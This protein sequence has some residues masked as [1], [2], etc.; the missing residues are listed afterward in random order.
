MMDRRHFAL[1][2]ASVLA[3]AQAAPALAAKPP[4]TWDNLV[5]VKSK[6]LDYVYLLPGADFREYRKVMIDPTEIAFK[7]NWLKDYNNT[8]T[9]LSTRLSERDVQEAITKGSQAATEIL[10]EAFSEGGYPVVTEPGPDVLRLRTGV[11]NI[12]V[13]APEINMAGRSRSF[14]QEAGYATLIVE[15]RDSVSGALLGRAVDGKVA[16]DNS[17]L[18]RTSVSNRAD[19]RQIMKRWATLSVKGLSELKA[20]SPINDQGAP[21]G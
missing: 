12:S 3:V 15:A 6:K 8:T 19:F 13:S 7:K 9:G 2:A 4:P 14:S 1:A 21:Q 16:G 11:V 5:R 18:M 17:M 10:T 20:V